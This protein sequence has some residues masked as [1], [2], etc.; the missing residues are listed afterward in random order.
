MG[1]PIFN[2]MGDVKLANIKF[3]GFRK[4]AGCPTEFVSIEVMNGFLEMLFGIKYKWNIKICTGASFA[5]ISTATKPPRSP[6]LRIFILRP[7]VIIPLPG[8]RSFEEYTHSFT[9][10]SPPP[11]NGGPNA[12]FQPSSGTHMRNGE[13]PTAISGFSAVNCESLINQ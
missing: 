1:F 2:G 6:K 13:T 10:P 8:K 9:L 12:F 11:T 5:L 4:I 7:G 3:Y